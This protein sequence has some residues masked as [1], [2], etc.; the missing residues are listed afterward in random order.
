MGWRF[1]VKNLCASVSLWQ[2]LIKIGHKGE[3]CWSV[4]K[5]LQLFGKSSSKRNVQIAVGSVAVSLDV[6]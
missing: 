5:S 6:P 3:I 2:S 1:L 4:K